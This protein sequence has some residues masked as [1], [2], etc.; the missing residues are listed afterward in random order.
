MK[1]G[2][3]NMKIQLEKNYKQKP[4]IFFYTTND[5]NIKKLNS[6]A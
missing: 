5:L 3:N 6:L 4:V 1:Q 2:K